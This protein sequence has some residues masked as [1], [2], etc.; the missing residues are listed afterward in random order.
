MEEV[1]VQRIFLW[2]QWKRMINDIFRALFISGI[3]CMDACEMEIM[4]NACMIMGSFFTLNIQTSNDEQQNEVK[5]TNKQ[6]KKKTN[7]VLYT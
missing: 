7:E 4:R 1:Q 5:I 3:L 2:T 6:S